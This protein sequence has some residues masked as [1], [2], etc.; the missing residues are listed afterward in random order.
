MTATQAGEK[1]RAAAKVDSGS[2]FGRL[3]YALYAAVIL[4]WGTS[5]IGIRYQ[6]GV[7]PPSVSVAYRFIIAALI[8]FA[9]VIVSRRQLR[10]PLAQHGIFLVMGL[11]LFSTNFALFYYAGQYLVTGL[12]ALIFSTAVLMNMI[13]S[14]IFLGEPARPRVILAG[15]LGFC[16]LATIFWPQIAARGF[17]A[18]TAIGLVLGL[19][20]ALSFSLGNMVSASQQ[21]RGVP[22]VSSTAWG[23]A[24][25]SLLLVLYALLAGEAFTF[26][27]RPSYVFSLVWLA[28]FASVIAFAT[29]LPLLRR[30]GPA[31]AGYVTVVFPL[32][33]LLISTFV[34]GYQWTVPAIAGL[35]MVLAGNVVVM[36]RH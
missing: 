7:V 26:D 3:D 35:A 28:I 13:N 1:A 29:Y 15:L 30:I 24:Y 11:F 20:G 14:M 17:D 19:G 32:L 27:L 4:F 5:W 10:F 2:G 36:R 23:M 33:A 31:R 12:L 16:G 18:G 9:W 8:M 21:R 34:E 22:M 25:G 6:L